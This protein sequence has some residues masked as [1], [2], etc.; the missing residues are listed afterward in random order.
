M[1][2]NREQLADQLIGAARAIREATEDPGLALG[3]LHKAEAIG[4]HRVVAALLTAAHA[5]RQGHPFSL[6]GELKAHPLEVLGWWQDHVAELE[7]LVS[8]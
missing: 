6:D 7:A 3:V 1:N 4:L 2:P 8:R 5:V